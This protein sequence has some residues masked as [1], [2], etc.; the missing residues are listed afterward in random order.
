M[1]VDQ[2]CVF[3]LHLS[4]ISGAC[5]QVGVLQVRTSVRGRE[6]TYGYYRSP[7]TAAYVYDAIKVNVRGTQI[8]HT[9]TALNFPEVFVK[10][11]THPGISSL[12]APVFS[13]VAT[14]QTYR[15]MAD[16]PGLLPSGIAGV[17]T[18]QSGDAAGTVFL[19]GR[20]LHGIYHRVRKPLPFRSLGRA[21]Y[22]ITT[23]WFCRNLPTSMRRP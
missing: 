10:L 17:A 18:K 8:I 2:D 7:K 15:T 21:R 23:D 13:D 14:F 20:K 12:P 22:H 3:G 9:P 1:A 5:C 11:L 16:G 19:N 4:V 6:F